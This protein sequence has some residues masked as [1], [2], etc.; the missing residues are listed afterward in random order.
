MCTSLNSL[1]FI[2]FAGYNLSTS[3]YHFVYTLQNYRYSVNQQILFGKNEIIFR[4]MGK[5]QINNRVLAAVGVVLET[6]K[7]LTKSAFAKLLDI[8]PSTFTEI[9][10]GRMNAS[11]EL[12]ALLVRNYA[13]SATWLLTGQ[14]NMLK[15]DEA[16]PT[17]YTG[18]GEMLVSDE[19]VQYNTG[20]QETMVDK[21]L[22]IIDKKDN[23]IRE[24]AEDI[25]HLRS[26][27]EQL[28]QRLQSSAATTTETPTNAE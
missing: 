14:G 8:K 19:P 24:Q 25:G 7:E 12:M 6:H 27:L 21:L 2:T 22:G 23:I 5:E 4:E 16:S 28:K 1:T 20:P 17:Q 26:E 13:V 15:S 9:L 18:T 10:K 11:S 3:L